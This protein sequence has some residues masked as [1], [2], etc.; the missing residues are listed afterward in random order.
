MMLISS[1][2][3][4]IIRVRVR[5]KLTKLTAEERFLYLSLYGPTKEDREWIKQLS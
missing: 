2:V 4:W 1:L 5:K 3:L